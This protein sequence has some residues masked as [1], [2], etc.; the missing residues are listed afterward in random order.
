MANFLKKRLSREDDKPKAGTES[1]ADVFGA[2][3]AI[4]QSYQGGVGRPYC[5]I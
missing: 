4:V 2:R 1:V 5:A 3:V